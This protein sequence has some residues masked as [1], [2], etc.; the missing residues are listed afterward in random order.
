[1][2][3]KNTTESVIKLSYSQ[4]LK[5]TETFLRSI[6][7]FQLEENEISQYEQGQRRGVILYWYALSAISGH[8]QAER[9]KDFLRLKQLAGVEDPE[10]S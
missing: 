4:L 7:S 8:S 9:E 1:M 5:E 6:I 3:N 10:A 2:E